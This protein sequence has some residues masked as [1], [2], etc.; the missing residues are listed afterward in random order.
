MKQ[1][2]KQI[3]PWTGNKEGF[4]F[5]SSVSS[6]RR[7]DQIFLLFA[8]LVAK[9]GKGLSFFVTKLSERHACCCT[10]GSVQFPCQPSTCCGYKLLFMPRVSRLQPNMQQPC[11]NSMR[12]L[13]RLLCSYERYIQHNGDSFFSSLEKLLD[14]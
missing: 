9:K 3:F 11:Y 6:T 13:L 1:Y 2:T 10:T 14:I 4:C 12:T 5:T 7:F 8:P